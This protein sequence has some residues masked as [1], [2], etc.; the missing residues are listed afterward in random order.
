MLWI[1][2]DMELVLQRLGLSLW[3]GACGA[4]TARCFTREAG[5]D[6]GTLVAGI[7]GRRDVTAR[8]GDDAEGELSL[9]LGSQE[10]VAGLPLLLL[11]GWSAVAGGRWSH[12][13][14]QQGP[15]RRAGGRAISVHQS[16]V[17]TV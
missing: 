3:S 12:A 11:L 17:L 1:T 5:P 4:W 14:A 15:A 7:V 6:A 13:C 10:R 2:H 8:G 16:G 9:A